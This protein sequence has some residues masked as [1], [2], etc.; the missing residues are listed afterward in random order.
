MSHHCHHVRFPFHL[1]DLDHHIVFLP[2]WILNGPPLVVVL[3][4]LQ[5]CVAPQVHLA[6]L[7]PLLIY[8]L[9]FRTMTFLL[10]SHVY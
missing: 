8:L 2:L 1:L 9:L 6:P 7:G 10:A 4:A 3:L 5:V